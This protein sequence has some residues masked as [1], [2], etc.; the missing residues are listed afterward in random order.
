MWEEIYILLLC[1]YMV[2]SEISHPISLLK[3][4]FEKLNICDSVSCSVVSNASRPHGLYSPG[5]SVHGILQAR[6]LAWAAIHFFRGFS[7]P[8]D[9]TQIFPH[10]RQI[11]NCLRHK[12]SQTY[13]KLIAFWTHYLKCFNKQKTMY[14]RVFRMFWWKNST[15][16]LQVT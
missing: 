7:R 1:S 5:S 16:L 3:G 4:Y 15:Q 2:F 6:I 14:L 10:C 9:W 8:W 12:G 13:W 11:L